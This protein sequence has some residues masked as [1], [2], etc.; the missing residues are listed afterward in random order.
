MLKQFPQTTRTKQGMT[1]LEVILAI[2]VAGLLL[3]AATSLV[4]SLSSIWMSRQD[5]NFFDDHAD[6]V[7]EFIRASFQQAGTEIA[8]DS[9]TDTPEAEPDATPP[10]PQPN[11]DAQNPNTNSRS[12]SGGL[13]RVSETPVAWARPPDYPEY[14]QPL[15]SFAYQKPPPLLSAAGDRARSTIQAYL[16]FKA[17]EGLSLL[18]YSTLQEEIEDL[19][20]LYHTTISPLVSGIQ[21]RYWDPDFERWEVLDSPKEDETAD[22]EDYLLPQS[23]IL[24]FSREDDTI[25]RTITIPITSRSTLIY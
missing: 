11:T 19:Q 1:L 7:A 3:T 21:Y 4:T 12:S 5:R 18:W 10:Q 9:N 24:S 23:I 25:A 14:E 22:S 16:Y 13:L 17:D 15:L 20:D 2:A 6:G 8:L